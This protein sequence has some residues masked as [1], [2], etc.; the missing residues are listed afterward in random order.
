VMR[1]TEIS[2]LGNRYLYG[3]EYESPRSIEG[4]TYFMD[5]TAKVS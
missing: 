2:F 3:F 5:W 1:G 4:C